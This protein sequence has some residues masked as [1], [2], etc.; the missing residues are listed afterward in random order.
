MW[1]KGFGDAIISTPTQAQWDIMKKVLSEVEINPTHDK[2]S[3]SNSLTGTNVT[4]T[5]GK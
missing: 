3:T 1:L 2:N 4:Y 5:V